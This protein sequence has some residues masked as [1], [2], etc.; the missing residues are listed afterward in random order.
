MAGQSWARRAQETNVTSKQ[1]EG[2]APEDRIQGLTI[3]V[4]QVGWPGARQE[5]N[6]QT[7]SA[8]S[9]AISTHY[10]PSST[11]DFWEKY[12]KMVLTTATL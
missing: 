9:Y 5:K 1:P 12:K 8:R 7:Q 6:S 3:Q 10:L 11:V 2:G 4:G